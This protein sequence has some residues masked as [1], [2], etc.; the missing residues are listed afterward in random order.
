M[1]RPYGIAKTLSHLA[2]L[3]TLLHMDFT[4]R[5]VGSPMWSSLCDWVG[6]LAV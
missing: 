1:A 4:G 6:T 2:S 5:I 3:F